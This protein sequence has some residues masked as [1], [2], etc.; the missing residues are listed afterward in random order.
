MSNMNLI[1]F[2]TLFAITLAS[3][4]GYAVVHCLYLSGAARRRMPTWLIVLILAVLLTVP[5][6]DLNYLA[7][8]QSQQQAIHE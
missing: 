7:T 5:R 6:L 2:I 4:L 1:L 8:R 3:G